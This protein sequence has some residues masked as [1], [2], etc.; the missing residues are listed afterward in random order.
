MI[1]NAF[2]KN[3]R[4]ALLFAI[5][6]GCFILSFL[7]SFIYYVASLSISLVDFSI[8]TTTMG[9]CCALLF[10]NV[11]EE[12]KL[13]IPACFGLLAFFT[14]FATISSIINLSAHILPTAAGVLDLIAT[15][16]LLVNSIFVVAFNYCGNKTLIKASALLAL[17]IALLSFISYIILLA[18]AFSIATLF[19]MFFELGLVLCL[20]FGNYF[21]Y[22]N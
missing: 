16:T 17:L 5:G 8:I 3:G 7:T 11:N 22:K 4:S 2:M 15:L 6:F 10:F 12:N 19:T 13:L 9:F 14:F 20:F 21:F 18:S 1:K